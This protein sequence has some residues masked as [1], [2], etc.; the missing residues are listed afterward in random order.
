MSHRPGKLCSVWQP[1]ALG[2][3]AVAELKRTASLRAPWRG[4]M[5]KSGKLDGCGRSGSGVTVP[6]HNS[7]LKPMRRTALS[8]VVD[9]IRLAAIC[10]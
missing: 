8:L 2:H 4:A 10:W 3:V 9:H 5:S 6:Y 7:L 1:T